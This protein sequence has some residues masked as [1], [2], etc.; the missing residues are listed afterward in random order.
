[1]PIIAES[2]IEDF[3]EFDQETSTANIS[4]K[5]IPHLEDIYIFRIRDDIQ[6]F[7]Q[8]NSFLVSILFEAHVYINYFFPLY[9]QK[10]LNV[11]SDPEIPENIQLIIS[12]SAKLN[13]NEAFD[14]LKELDEYWWLN[15]KRQTKGLM[16]ITVEFG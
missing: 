8:K 15:A 3:T 7:L 13:A 9:S 6:W 10:I 5:V 4:E 2:E 16:N 1:M 11:V 14:C 12:I